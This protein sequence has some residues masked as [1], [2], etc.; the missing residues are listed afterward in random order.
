LAP[1]WVAMLAHDPKDVEPIELAAK[2]IA[3]KGLEAAALPYARFASVRH[4]RTHAMSNAARTLGYD[5]FVHPSS[6]AEVQTLVQE[7]HARGEQVRVRG[8]LHSESGSVLADGFARN[9]GKRPVR[10]LML[11]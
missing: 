7:A 10:Q 3:H 8:A 11:D 5:D 4:L 1:L 2:G 9:G 6:I